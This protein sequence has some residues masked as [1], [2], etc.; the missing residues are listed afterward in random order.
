MGFPTSSVI[1]DVQ[2]LLEVSGSEI[3]SSTDVCNALQSYGGSLDVL[4]R[5][6]WSSRV[7]TVEI[8]DP[9]EGLV[10]SLK[11]WSIV[12]VRSSTRS[13]EC[14]FSPFFISFHLLPYD[15][16]PSVL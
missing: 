7:F 9:G 6:G 12:S 1:G 13:H 15:H 10:E 3:Q 8:R 11:E 2:R 14:F 16:M 5:K 4:C